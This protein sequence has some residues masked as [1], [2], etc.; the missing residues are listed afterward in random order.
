[1]SHRLPRHLIRS[2]P[3]QRR[4]CSENGCDLTNV[5][6]DCSRRKCKRHCLSSGGCAC[7]QSQTTPALSPAFNLSTL[8]FTAP[9]RLPHRQHDDQESRFRLSHPHWFQ[10]TPSPPAPA[11][12]ESVSFTL[13]DFA[14]SGRPGTVQTV[15]TSSD[16]WI[17][18][19]NMP[20][21]TYSTTYLR[22]MPVEASYAHEVRRGRRIL[23]RAPGIDGSNQDLHIAT[24]LL[25]DETLNTRLAPRSSRPPRPLPRSPT[26]PATTADQA[27]R[28]ASLLL[29]RRA[30]RLSSS[31]P[32]RPLPRSPSPPASASSSKRKR[33][34]TE[35]SDSEVEIIA[36]YPAIKQE[37]STPPRCHL[38]R[39]LSVSQPSTSSASSSATPSSPDFPPSIS[40]P[41]RA[42]PESH[43]TRSF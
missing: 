12:Q 37:K 16:W 42:A 10:M 8:P 40:L 29:D 11:P 24:L 28:I 25:E 23:I 33:S 3:R 5:N 26:P 4:P 36:Y 17:R 35:D 34:A 32:P 14:E 2:H 18:P 27:I 1:M 20:Y 31:R 43:S 22:W 38:R 7:H 19:G 13:I 41:E 6:K 21:E 15:T 30:P 39:R 9:P